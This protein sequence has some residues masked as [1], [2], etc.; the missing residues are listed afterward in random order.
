M[1]R[2]VAQSVYEELPPCEDWTEVHISKLLQRVVAKVS[3]YVFIGSEHCREEVYID[4]SINYTMDV[5]TARLKVKDTAPWKRPFVVPFFQ[6]IKNVQKRREQAYNF[7]RPIISARLEA[8]KKPEY[9][10]PDDMLQRLMD[11]Q[12]K[13]GTAKEIELMAEYQLGL[14]LAAI[15]TT[16]TSM[17][18]MYVRKN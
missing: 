1:T 17:L 14:S 2:E 6:E 15:L 8:Q 4:A 18:N 7:L 5:E 10:K 13:A 16:S 11:S 9:V 3:G 12:V